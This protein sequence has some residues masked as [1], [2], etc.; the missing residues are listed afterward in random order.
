MSKEIITNEAATATFRC[1][2]LPT[3]VMRSEGRGKVVVV[4][5]VMEVVIVVVVESLNCLHIR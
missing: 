1:Q 4:I 5:I 2:A 3:R